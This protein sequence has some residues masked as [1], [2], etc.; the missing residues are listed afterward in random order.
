MLELLRIVTTPLP[1]T[2]S[3]IRGQL[4]LFVA[5]DAL[6]RR[7]AGEGRSVAWTPPTLTGDLAAQLAVERDLARQGLDRASV[8]RDDFAERVRTYESAARDD[9]KARLAR[10][11]VEADLEGGSTGTDV[12]VR[13]ARTAFVRLYEAGLLRE[14]ERVVDLCPHC[15]VVVDDVDAETVELDATTLTVRF[16]FADTEAHAPGGVDVEVVAAELLTGTVAVA[17]APGD[18]RAGREVVV[19]LVGRAVPVVSDDS[20]TEP[21]ALVPSHDAAAFE[22]ARRHGLGPL[23][24]L[25]A[26]ATVLVVPLQGL[27]RYAA[28]AAA[29]D[30]L[31]AEGVLLA[32]REGVERV[33]R[34]R[35]CSTVVL[36][37][38][39]RHWFL[40]MG[41]LEIAAADAARD[42]VTF[43][44]PILRDEFL[45]LASSTREWCLSH[46]GWSGLPVPVARCADCGSTAVSVDLGESCGKCMGGLIPDERVLDPRF[47]GAVWPLADAAWPADEASVVVEATGTTMLVRPAG[48]RRWALPMAALGLRLAGTIP[49]AAVACGAVDAAGDAADDDSGEEVEPAAV[50]VA[51]LRGDF[52]LVAAADDV[53]S[54]REPAIGETDLDALADAYDDALASGQ[55]SVALAILAAAARDGVRAGAA[56]RVRALAAP[57]L[58]D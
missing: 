32:E 16:A 8:G 18:E 29:A 13:A 12:A 43:A 47:V 15:S 57:L 37:G 7:G 54:L 21:V 19:P 9:L 41:D 44:P 26:Q 30:L 22:V 39:A 51:A 45:A 53:A 40:A 46:R 38:L 4:A 17:V 31:A 35:R 34:C 42:S 20:V 24:V 5:A 33:A 3:P 36:A 48:L 55:P 14:D 52:D 23:E 28:R 11:G 6:V 49:F 50:R 56:D 27:S 25:D 2:G 1:L 58:G 10:L